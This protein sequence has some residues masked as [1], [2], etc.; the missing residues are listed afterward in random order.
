[1]DVEILYRFLSMQMSISAWG[2]VA[3]A[4]GDTG[5]PIYRPPD[6]TSA[7]FSNFESSVLHYA[8]SKE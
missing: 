7:P 4:M 1:L 5:D 3:R 8:E 6:P 2:F